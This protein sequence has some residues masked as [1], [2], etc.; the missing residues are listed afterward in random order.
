MTTGLYQGERLRTS[1]D[2]TA[3]LTSRFGMASAATGLVRND[4]VDLSK[5]AGCLSSVEW[6][7]SSEVPRWHAAERPPALPCVR[8][9]FIFWAMN[10]HTA[11]MTFLDVGG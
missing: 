4:Q 10:D 7:A 9:G 11:E 3:R 1:T 6:A 2:S 5:A 8:S